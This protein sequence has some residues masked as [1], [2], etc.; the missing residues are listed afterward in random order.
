MM[1]LLVHSKSKALISASRSRGSSNFVAPRVDEPALRAR[2]RVVG[3]HVALDAAVLDRREIVARRPGARG[4]LLAEQ[5]ALGGE[6]FEADLA[7]AIVL[8]AHD[9][10]IVLAARDRQIGAPPVL[11]ALVFDE[12]AGLEASDLVG[13]RAERRVE[14]RFIERLLL[15]N[16]R[17]RRSAGR[18]R[19]AARRAR[20]SAQNARPRS[21]RRLAS[22]PR[23]SRS[24]LGDERV[25]LLLEDIERE[26]DIV[27]GE[28][29]C[30]REICA[31]GRSKKR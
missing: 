3:Q 17:A 7:V 25:A 10:E 23:K 31:C 13:A 12:A 14:R 21:R 30:R 28:R 22:A 26:G 8:E 18:R 15:R 5:I 24:E 2:R 16:R 6:A 20:A 11:D 19:T 29:A 9:V 27:R 1:V 4:E